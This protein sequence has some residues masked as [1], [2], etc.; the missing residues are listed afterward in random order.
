MPATEFSA[1]THNPYHL[2]S[3][4]SLPRA[5]V[6]PDSADAALS[7]CATA[8]GLYLSNSFTLPEGVGLPPTSQQGCTDSVAPRSH[9]RN[10]GRP[11]QANPALQI[12]G[13]EAGGKCGLP[14]SSDQAT[15]G[16][17]SSSLLSEQTLAGDSPPG[18][19]PSVRTVPPQL[20][21][22]APAGARAY[23]WVQYARGTRTDTGLVC[24][25]CLGKRSCPATIPTGQARPLKRR[26]SPQAQ[27]LPRS[28]AQP[29]A[30]AARPPKEGEQQLFARSASGSLRQR[31]LQQQLARLQPAGSLQHSLAPL[32]QV[33]EDLHTPPPQHIPCSR[34]GAPCLT[35]EQLPVCSRQLS[36][37]P[38][39][40]KQLSIPP[41]CGPSGLQH[42]HQQ[43]PDPLQAQQQQ[44][45]QQLSQYARQDPS[46]TLLLLQHK[47]AQ[48]TAAAVAAAKLGRSGST[49]LDQPGEQI[50]AAWSL[51]PAYS[52]PV[53]SATTSALQYTHLWHARLRLQQGDTIGFT[54]HLWQRLRDWVR[55]TIHSPTCGKLC[56]LL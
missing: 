55:P 53:R 16:N 32:Q 36:A 10:R 39:S 3:R 6:G 28:C 50:P 49:G 25:G 4:G 21:Y 9:F 26:R 11:A 2:R 33:S 42:Q 56:P 12:G 37:A 45:Q 41:L 7:S 24:T 13:L 22:S 54:L 29:A 44:Q 43:R 20:A 5:Q 40:A 15:P 34:P 46:L 48:V 17:S 8:V 18:A 51:Q 23:E 19:I 31:C 47:Q 14:S 27:D 38:Y 52:A 30:A 35:R 1:A